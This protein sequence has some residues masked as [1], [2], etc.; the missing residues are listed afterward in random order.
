[1]RTGAFPPQV[2]GVTAGG[3]PVYMKADGSE[4]IYWQVDT[5]DLLGDLKVYSQ[6]RIGEPKFS[7]SSS[8][9]LQPPLASSSLPLPSPT[10]SL[11]SSLTSSRRLR[12]DA[13]APT[14]LSPGPQC[15]A[16][17]ATGAACA[18]TTPP[19]AGPSGQASRGD[20]ALRTSLHTSI[21]TPLHASICTSLHTKPQ[22]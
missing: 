3:K 20:A 16:P 1:M 22:T 2:S 12:R 6:W 17:A 14:T 5:T 13:Q 9:L 11:T 4:Y 10:S 8:H 15:T 7:L 18:P 21:H 19:W